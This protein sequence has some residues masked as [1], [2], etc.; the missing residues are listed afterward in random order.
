[1]TRRCAVVVFFR[2]STFELHSQKQPTPRVAVF[3]L[4]ASSRAEAERR[5]VTAFRE[6]EALP[7][8]GWVGAILCVYIFVIKQR[9]G[10]ALA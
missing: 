3:E 8:V 9:A 5:A 2:E 7:S 6:A 1:M 4:F 10:T